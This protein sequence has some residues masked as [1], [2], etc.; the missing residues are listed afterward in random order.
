[1]SLVPHK[2]LFASA[3]SIRDRLQR[4]QALFE[5]VHV[6]K[7]VNLQKRFEEMEKSDTGNH[8]PLQF[9]SAL[10]RQLDRP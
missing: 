8:R 7:N 10:R 1:M 6:R 2:F 9:T 5:R 4:N 3:K